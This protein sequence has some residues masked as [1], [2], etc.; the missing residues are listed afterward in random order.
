MNLGMTIGKVFQASKPA[1]I[2][3][4]IRF[5]SDLLKTCFISGFSYY[6]GTMIDIGLSP[7]PV[8]SYITSVRDD[9]L[10]VMVTASHNPPSNNG[11]KFFLNGRECGED[12]EVKVEKSLY[13]ESERSFID[14]ISPYSWKNVGISKYE[15]NKIYIDDYINHLLNN[16]K[17]KNQGMKIILDCANNV[18]NLVSPYVLKH[19]G[20]DVISIN[21]TLDATFPG[22]SS[23]PTS[24][25]LS[26]LKERVIE[27]SANIGIAHDGDGDRF[28]LIDEQG[29]FVNSTTIINFFLD[30]L[31]YSNPD[32]RKIV[33]TSD[34]TSQAFEIA[35]KNK[36][37]VITSRIGRNR[38]FIDDNSVI[39]LGEPNK[40]LFPDFG[41]WIDGLYPVLKFL[42][43]SE[44][45]GVSK[46]LKPYDK[47]KILRK[48]FNITDKHKKYVKDVINTL[49]DLW[50]K[51]ISRVSSLDGLKLYFNDK[52]CLLIRF[53]GTEPK[54]K[55]YIES[56]SVKKNWNI[57]S[58][59]T[60]EF[61]L[62]TK[63]I[64]C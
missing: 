39:F 60:T 21:D 54:I 57:L 49:P 41:K 59:L 4:D 36:A 11:F 40:L 2:A 27:E 50:S 25:K 17:I 63:G 23:E 64:D 44:L 8:I 30:H 3:S 1:Y 33:L 35:E 6:S 37:E 38:D 47:R 24:E 15:N 7:T 14:K 58:Q 52:S 13:Y 5:T 53:S 32:R 20:F 10:G 46:I 16:I 26:I 61:E 55:F 45:N 48:A 29:H 51:K 22:R 34:C 28:A 19:F 56:H 18:P 62:N 31:D 42:D 43:L 9:T 12:F